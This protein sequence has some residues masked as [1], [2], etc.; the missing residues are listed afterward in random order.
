[1]YY[2]CA[3]DVHNSR[4][5]GSVL[6]GPRPAPL[7]QAQSMGGLHGGR[8][9]MR[10]HQARMCSSRTRRHADTPTC[11]AV[12]TPEDHIWP[13][14]WSFL[15]CA[16][17]TWSHA[18]DMHKTPAPSSNV[19]HT[20]TPTVTLLTREAQSNPCWGVPHTATPTAT[21]MQTQTHTY[22]LLH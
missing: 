9:E 4:A 7:T 20:K 11:R 22:A 2:S 16:K 12:H 13:H 5:A 21:H 17:H 14:S 3:E 6:A 1:M 18:G 8:Q 15:P 10:G 19:P